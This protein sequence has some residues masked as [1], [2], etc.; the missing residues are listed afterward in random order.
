MTFLVVSQLLCVY[1]SPIPG[2]PYGH[3]LPVTRPSHL[4]C[5][6]AVLFVETHAVSIHRNLLSVVTCPVLEAPCGVCT[7]EHDD[8]HGFR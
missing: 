7:L 4:E 2:I 8:V 1:M 6:K 3:G 5:N